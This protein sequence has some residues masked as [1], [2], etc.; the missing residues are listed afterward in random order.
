MKKIGD[1]TSTAD[2][3][4][5]WTNGNVAAGIPPTILESGWLNSVQREI[6]G[7]LTKAGIPQDKNND[8]QLSE[9]ISKIITGGNYA[10]AEDLKKKLTKNENGADI[11]DKPKF[12]ENLGLP[13]KYQ[14]KGNYAPTGNY[15]YKGDSYTKAESNNNYQPKGNYQAEGYS[16]SKAESDNKYQFTGSSYSKTESDNLYLG[17][18]NNVRMTERVVW[19]GRVQDRGD[20]VCTESIAGCLV[21]LECEGV[22]LPTPVPATSRRF[23]VQWTGNLWGQMEFIS[24]ETLRFHNGSQIMTKVLK[25]V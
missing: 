6:L 8:N 7:V 11:P 1:V 20:M 4:G 9:A 17:K 23:N 16:Y 25:S 24:P 21:Y 18:N 22:W 3:N 15:A 19:T 2:K 5:E 13:E 10:T 14:P 12:I